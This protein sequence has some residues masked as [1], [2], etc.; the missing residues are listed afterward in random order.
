MSNIVQY[1]TSPIRR[2]SLDQ[3]NMSLE[4]IMGAYDRGDYELAITLWRLLAEDGD[5]TAQHNLGIMY[6]NGKGVRKDFDEA[7]RWYRKAAEQGDA[8]SQY[9]LGFMY[10]MG[11]GVP[12]DYTLGEM[13]L[14]LANAQYEQSEAEQQDFALEK[15]D[16]LATKL[17]KQQITEAQFVAAKLQDAARMPNG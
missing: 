13:W 4:S 6:E 14:G 3:K 15:H 2:R 10:L 1:N 9:D 17:T 12:Q 5:I 8:E 16:R 11:Q 7:A